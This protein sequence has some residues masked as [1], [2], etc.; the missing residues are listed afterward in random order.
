M[1]HGGR[2][3][4]IK[5]DVF[6]L[7]C[8]DLAEFRYTVVLNKNVWD[9]S[10]GSFVCLT[11]RIARLVRAP[12]EGGFPVNLHCVFSKINSAYFLA[13][14]VLV[15]GA[16]PAL[17]QQGV[18][19]D[20]STHHVIFSDPGSEMDALMNG[21]RQEWEK[22]TN[23]PRYQMQK[24]RRSAEWA[25]RLGAVQSE[26]SEARMERES[27]ARVM[28]SDDNGSLN[29]DWA[30]EVSPSPTGTSADMYPAFYG[31]SFTTASCSD[32]IVFPVN[33]SGNS[34]QAS[35]VGFNNLYS[36]TCTGTVP[37]VAFA[38]NVT[39]NGGSVRTSPS[40]SE[41]GE[42]LAFI[43]SVHDG[44]IFD[45]LTPGTTGSNGTA[46]NAPASPGNGN[47]AKLVS[48]KL[49]GD[50][51]DPRSSP[52]VDYVDDVAY[53]GDGSGHLHKITCVFNR[54]SSSCTPAEVTT[55]GWPF[56]V[57]V[58]APTLSGPAYDSTSK[59]I[60]VGGSDGNLYCV[61]VSGAVPLAC[62]TPSVS[63]ADGSSSS[64]AVLDGPIVD[65]TAETV[66]S[67]AEANN[68]GRST[69]SVLMQ[70]TT[71][72][73]GVI[74]VNMG[75]GGT[76]LYD[77]DFDN[78]YYSSNA[79]AYTGYLYFCGNQN[80]AATPTLY[81]IGF[82]TSGTMNSSRDSSSYQ[83]VT[84]G[85]TGPET[86]CTPLTENFNG[87]T[88]YMFLGVASYG[89]PTGCVVSTTH[90]GC[91]M[92]FVVGS[93][94]GSASSIPSPTAEFPLGGNTKGASGI[95]VDNISTQAGA[96][97]IYFDNLQNG[98]ATQVSQ[99]SLH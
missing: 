22:I 36:G 33:M 35:L 79:G 16:A 30:V 60:F 59:H 31:A 1:V 99:A 94:S 76:N 49:S 13:I 28:G 73:S 6:I 98:D 84:T 71:S 68:S 95:V 74:R 58:A 72:L 83:L 92:N 53:V 51:S 75:D 40:V 88:D 12:I 45:V 96:S 63:V 21:H 77:G 54:N 70:A 15:T 8:I 85:E 44:S 48:I 97:Q 25:N 7:F 5:N 34:R 86:N 11:K 27:Q 56:L 57:S 26:I 93:S 17:A 61:N 23:N 91:I 82:N 47:N 3:P 64:G 41:N 18:V 24:L 4:S 14:A 46:Y 67:E 90:E 69:E 9:K 43:E 66:F 39:V 52:F 32:F 81:R 55:G 2:F 62:T 78:A 80:S 50:V 65:G 29:R 42:K 19:N 37:K 20:W 89:A 87:T 38:Y 10:R